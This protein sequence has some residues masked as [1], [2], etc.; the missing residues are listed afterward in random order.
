[1]DIR[2]DKVPNGWIAVL[3]LTAAALR[4]WEEGFAGLGIGLCHMLLAFLLLLPIFAFRALGAADIKIF[5]S[6]SILFPL[7]DMLFLFSS[8]V[9][10]GAVI[11]IVMRARAY[12]KENTSFHY[13]HFT[14]PI[15]LSVLL[16]E[17]GGVYEL[18]IRNL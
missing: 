12:L 8:S 10:I 4:F 11:G 15:W 9:V 7:Q 1:M 14:I 16:Y 13:I 5:L 2:T 18:F 17:Y 3:F 6:L